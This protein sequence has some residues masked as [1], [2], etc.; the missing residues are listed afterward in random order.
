MKRLIEIAQ[1]KVKIFDANLVRHQKE[2]RDY[3]LELSI[4]KLLVPHMFEARCV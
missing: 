4:Q 1:D 2:N 3:L